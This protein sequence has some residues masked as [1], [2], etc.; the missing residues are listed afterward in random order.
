MPLP[1]R[2]VSDG[3]DL[4]GGGRRTP[5][6]LIAAMAD[7]DSEGSEPDGMPVQPWPPELFRKRG[8]K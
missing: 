4:K 3:G 2:D 6:D 5:A 8:R 7:N 1:R